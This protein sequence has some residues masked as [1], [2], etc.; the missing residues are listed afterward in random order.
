MTAYEAVSLFYE[1]ANTSTNLLFGFIGLLSAFLIMSFFSAG[2]LSKIL[3]AIVL[4][5][6]SACSFL[7][8]MQIQLVRND[9][10]SLYNQILEFQSTG[11]ESLEWFAMNSP[12]L[13][14]LISVALNLVTIGGYLGCIAFFFYK[15]KEMY[16][17]NS[18]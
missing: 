18:T 15:R 9:M 17:D 8:I 13:V 12:S 14:A 5:L 2:E 6:F 1:L 7:L 16:S 10:E 3:M 11:L 4:A